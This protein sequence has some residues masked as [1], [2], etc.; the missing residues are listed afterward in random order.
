M[1]RMLV[2]TQ[3]GLSLSASSSEMVCVPDSVCMMSIDK[4]NLCLL[5]TSLI[6]GSIVVSDE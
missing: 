3:G 1:Q 5:V 6:K 4:A 2:S